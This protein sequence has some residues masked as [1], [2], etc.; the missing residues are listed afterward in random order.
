MGSK[1]EDGMK[2]TEETA[3]ICLKGDLIWGKGRWIAGM[4]QLYYTTTVIYE[5]CLFIHKTL[6]IEEFP[7]RG[8]VNW[9]K[10]VIHWDVNF[11]ICIVYSIVGGKRKDCSI[12]SLEFTFLLWQFFTCFISNKGSLGTG[13]WMGAAGVGVAHIEVKLKIAEWFSYSYCEK[14]N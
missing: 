1:T 2:K 14:S 6:V 8:F 10:T 7:S 4:E 13:G 12:L 11:H 9:G 3:W 5:L